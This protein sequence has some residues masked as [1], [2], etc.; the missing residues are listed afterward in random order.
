MIRTFWSSVQPAPDQYDWSFIDSQVQAAAASGK[1]VV[2]AVLPGAFT[3]S[4]ALQGVQ[5]ANS[6]RTMALFRAKP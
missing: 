5:S 3:P 6:L 2:L 1:K 4:W